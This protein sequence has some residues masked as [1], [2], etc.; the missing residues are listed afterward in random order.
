MVISPVARNLVALRRRIAEAAGR[1]GRD[2]GSVTLVGI[3]KTMP[4]ETIRAAVE[5]GLTDLGENRVQEARDKAPHLPGSVR[6]HLVGHLQTNKAIHAARLFQ[7]IHSIDS[8]ELLRRVD[9]AAG[10]E[11]RSI[12]AL[13]QVDLADGRRVAARRSATSCDLSPPR[14]HPVAGVRPAP[15][16][17]RQ[18]EV[19]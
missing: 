17:L 13:I 3:G 15:I 5:A 4:V 8:A 16:P 2:P 1:A 19:G 9:Q 10:R 6:W 7:V 12:D 11:G 14:T 18:P